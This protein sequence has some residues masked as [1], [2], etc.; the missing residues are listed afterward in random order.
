MDQ[1]D[2]VNKMLDNIQDDSKL[3]TLMKIDGVLDRLHVYAYKNWIEGEIVDGPHIDRY[4]VTATFLYPRKLMPDP[5]AAE[6][7][8]QFGGHVY[9]QK[10]TVVTAA[11][12]VEPED[13]DAPDGA[14]G[15]RPGQ[16]R[17]KKV[18]RPI[19]LVTVELPR[20]IMD[21]TETA[22]ARLADMNVDNDAVEEAYDDDLGDQ[23]VE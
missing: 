12:L 5:S 11:K 16:P 6:R 20:D 18:E 17:A 14:D 19:W 8:I 21:S 10:D 15:I 4:W 23:A 7:I 22:K 3:D 9:Y 13:S 1:M 2:I